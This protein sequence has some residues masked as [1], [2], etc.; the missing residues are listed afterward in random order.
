[1]LQTRPLS[2]LA[3]P[4]LRH[5]L[6]L[7]A[8]LALLPAGV[9]RST[10]AQSGAESANGQAQPAVDAELASQWADFNHYVL[11]ARPELAKAAGESLLQADPQALLDV[12]EA[13]DYSD[14]QDNLRRAENIDALSD[15]ASRLRDTIQRAR[16]SRARDDQRITRNIELLDDGQRPFSN[17]TE[18]LA[19]AGQYAAPHLLATLQNQSKQDLHPY[20]MSS[21]VQIGR[22]LVY[23]LSE[24]LP[25]LDPVRMQQV[26]QV[27]AQI[28]Y[29]LPL[30]YMQ[31]ILEREDVDP[32]A[33]SAV[34][35]AHDRLVERAKATRGRTAAQLFLRL[36]RDQYDAGTEGDELPG[37]DAANKEGVVWEYHNEVG[38]VDVHVPA[39]IHGDVLAMRSAERALS[40]KRDFSPALSVHLMANLRR[41]NNL[42]EGEQDPSYG[43]DM[44]PPEFYAML[45]GPKRLHDVL[46]QALLDRDPTLALDAINA[47]ADTAGT[48]ALVN[49]EAAR[50]PLLDA[51]TYPD[52][53]VRFRAAHALA[54][55]RPRG[56]F[57]EAQRVVPVLSEAIRQTG[58]KHALV[59]AAD[60]QTL[61]QRMADVSDL[62]YQVFGGLSLE[63]ARSEI[64]SRPGVDLLVIQK[65]AE[66]AASTFRSTEG[67]Y[68][69]GATP[70]LAL[71]GPAEQYQLRE[72]IGEDAARFSMTTPPAGE[73]EQSGNGDDESASEA[74]QSTPMAKAVEQVRSAYAGRE[75]SAEESRQ[76]ALTALQTL[77]QIALASDVYQVQTA[78]PTLIAALADDR[79]D[80]VKAAGGVLA[81]IDTAEA[82]QAIAQAA[83][84][85]SGDLQLAL[86]GSLA[87]SATHHGNLLEARQAERAHEMVQA[88]TG[89]LAIAAARAHG[90]LS[91]PT[92]RAVDM[93]LGPQSQ[94]GAQTA[95]Q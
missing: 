1:M 38:L 80:V 2:E 11:I 55:A 51:L 59:I 63:D 86:L 85:G 43:S 62:G 88:N 17:A 69:L 5:A 24:A 28:G 40:L 56:G 30:P 75:L 50:Q 60:Q 68:K 64:E 34:Q 39:A 16:I 61:N 71:A 83:L 72:L 74:L 32:T 92:E 95:S 54:A 87:D 9:L 26:A 10:H 23:P 94:D 13:G 65:P 73:D 22:P 47:L 29:P 79:P 4:R 58:E 27:L 44:Q 53:R 49:L 12:V 25:E 67:H 14:Y 45:A 31:Q 52:R 41:A 35:R 66:A 82:Q 21:M 57:P 6:L 20:V 7:V 76:F 46:A 8:L 15:V 81:V 36:A 19:G 89:D 48:E 18:R 70:V 91:L 33:K 77:E 90:A 3:R 78:L 93:I 37:Y 42:P 84:N